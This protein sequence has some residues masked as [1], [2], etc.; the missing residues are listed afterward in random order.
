[1][2]V[3]IMEAQGHNGQ[4]ELTDSILRIKRKGVP[5]VHDAGSQG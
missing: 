3:T 4:L 1:M 5:C 2:S